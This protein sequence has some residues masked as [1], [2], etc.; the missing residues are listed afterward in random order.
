LRSAG[1]RDAVLDA[2]A[3]RS[4]LGTAQRSQSTIVEYE[5]KDGARGWVSASEADQEG[6]AQGVDRPIRACDYIAWQISAIEGAP[7]CELYW[8]KEMRDAAV[9]ASAAFLKTYGHRLTAEPPPGERAHPS[10]KRAHLAFPILGRRAT[11]EAVR[12]GR[13]IFSLE[14]E[15]EIHGVELPS[16]PIK[17]NWIPPGAE[18]GGVAVDG[19][20]WQA[21]EVRQGGQWERYYGFV[22]RHVIAR[23]PGGSFEL[24]GGRRPA[25]GDR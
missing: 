6:V 22:G 10:E 24:A 15:G 18:R 19:W 12:A 7:R 5:L 13:A 9:E 21:E 2:M 23:V 8:M 3:M 16:M 4:E 1:F 20:V 25:P 14:G 11:K 17:A